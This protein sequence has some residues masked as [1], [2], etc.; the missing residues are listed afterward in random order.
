VRVVDGMVTTGCVFKCGASEE[1]L[2]T[3]IVAC[4]GSYAL[5]DVDR[6]KPLDKWIKVEVVTRICYFIFV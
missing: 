3:V 2:N 1:N 5:D 4:K 6:F